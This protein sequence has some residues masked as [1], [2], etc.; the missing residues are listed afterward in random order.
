MAAED[1]AVAII[2]TPLKFVGIDLKVV[3]YTEM[4]VS[5][6]C[7]VLVESVFFRGRGKRL[8]TTF[9]ARDPPLTSAC[10][11]ISWSI[12]SKIIIEGWCHLALVSQY[13]KSSRSLGTVFSVCWDR[14]TNSVSEKVQEQKL[15]NGEPIGDA[16]HMS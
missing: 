15:D 14:S 11:G 1:F 10:G 7:L 2:T 9:I 8:R 16:P 6:M 13:V 12:L 3:A 5:T 4:K